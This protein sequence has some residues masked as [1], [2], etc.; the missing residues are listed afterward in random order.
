MDGIG[1]GR[2][3]CSETGGWLLGRSKRLAGQECMRKLVVA[4]GFFVNGLIWGA[5]LRCCWLGMGVVV[6]AV[7]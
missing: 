3:F 2:G 7:Q 5:I 1:E 6:G 4:I